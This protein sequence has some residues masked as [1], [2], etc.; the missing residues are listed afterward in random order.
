MK[1][2]VLLVAVGS[3]LSMSFTLNSKNESSYESNIDFSD[4]NSESINVEDAIE[5]APSYRRGECFVVN[6]DG[7]LTSGSACIYSGT[8][9]GYSQCEPR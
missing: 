3:V 8:G 2:I 6:P 1:K 5:V 9:C 4:L 7:T